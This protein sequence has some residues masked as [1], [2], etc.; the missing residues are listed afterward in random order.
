MIPRRFS[1][2]AV[3][4][5]SSILAIAACGG[6]DF[7][8]PDR[9]ERVRAAE[10]QYASASFDSIGWESAKARLDEG[11][12]VYAEKCR[13]CH[14]QLGRGETDYARQRGL[15]VPSLVGAEWP[16][17][18][19]DALRRQVFIG[20]EDGMPIFGDAGLSLRDI[21]AVSAYILIELRPEVLGEGEGQ[22]G[23]G[24][25]G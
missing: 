22:G 8:P 11:N 25:G 13:R 6:H 1:L 14:G 16:F 10:A 20:H 9:G 5:V 17:D 2:P 7:E 23:G 15:D 18:Q 3:L 12:T 24:R 4:A 19:M 21:D